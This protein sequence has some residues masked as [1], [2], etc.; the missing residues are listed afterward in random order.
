MLGV[1]LLPALV[2]RGAERSESLFN[3]NAD[4]WLRAALGML[5]AVP[6]KVGRSAARAV[7][8]HWWD[9]TERVP[10]RALVKRRAFDIRGTV[11]PWLVPAALAPADLVEACGEEPEPL[12]MPA[13]DQAKGVVFADWVTLEIRPSDDLREQPPFTSYGEMITQADFP[14]LVAEVRR[15]NLAIFGER[16][17]RPD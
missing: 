10:D 4:A 6:V 16:A 3:T 1:R 8:G 15:Q 13:P 7:D 17:D 11:R 5:E 2:Y 12:L 9:S 14:A